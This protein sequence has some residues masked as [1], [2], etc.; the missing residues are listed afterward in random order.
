MSYSFFRSP[1]PILLLASLAL[2][3][4]SGGS[5]DADADNGHDS[6][7]GA[8]GGNDS[9][10]STMDMD[11]SDVR[12]VRD[13]QADI[14]LEAANSECLVAM[15]PT[16]GSVSTQFTATGMG[17]P[18]NSAITLELAPMGSVTGGMVLQMFPMGTPDD[19]G[20]AGFTFMFTP[21]SLNPVPTP[22]MYIIRARDAFYT[23]TFEAPF[24]IDP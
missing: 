7:M 21:S 23:C 3:A 18:A 6:S 1:A 14:A 5:S 11:A 4:C 2:G 16:H 9:D 20:T 10:G 13:G 17:F 15:H 12:R 8:D 24:T 19:A 22:G